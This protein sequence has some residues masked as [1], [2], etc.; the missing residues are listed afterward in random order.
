MVL[1]L[2]LGRLLRGYHEGAHRHVVRTAME[3]TGP[4]PRDPDAPDEPQDGSVVAAG[5]P[6]PPPG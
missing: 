2:L 5:A 3:L 6:T 4:T 1:D